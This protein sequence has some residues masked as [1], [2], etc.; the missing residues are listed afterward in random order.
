MRHSGKMKTPVVLVILAALAS[1]DEA[2][3]TPFCARGATGHH[4]RALI[5]TAKASIDLASYALTD[6]IVI[7]ALDAA[8]ARGVKVRIVLVPRERHAFVALGDLSDNVR[9]KRGGPCMHLK[10]FQID[11]EFLRTGNANFSASGERDQDNDLIILR[12]PAAAV[13]FEAHFETMWD[14]A[15]PMIEFG[16]AIQAL[17]PR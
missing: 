7:D 12:D 4:R 16:P 2:Q 6:P 10:S 1:R 3:E 14:V 11:G 17:E 9:I 13:K 5:A 8:E 15:E